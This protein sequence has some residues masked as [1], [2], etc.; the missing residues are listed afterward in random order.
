ML[1]TLS[2]VNKLGGHL[3]W[4]KARFRIVTLWMVRSLV[5]SKKGAEMVQM[6]KNEIEKT[7]HTRTNPFRIK[8]D[9]PAVVKGVSIR[10]IPEQVTFHHYSR[11][12]ISKVCLHR[13]TRYTPQ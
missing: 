13:Y 5:S 8:Y 10:I 2:K 3:L 4:Q 9:V 6:I 12:P 7:Q 11:L 1:K